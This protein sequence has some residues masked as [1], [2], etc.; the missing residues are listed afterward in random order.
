[1]KIQIYGELR[2]S[3]YLIT[4]SYYFDSDYQR[5]SCAWRRPQKI[6]LEPFC[7]S[8]VQTLRAQNFFFL[9]TFGSARSLTIILVG[10]GPGDPSSNLGRGCLHFT[11][12]L[13]AFR[14]AWIQQF[15]PQLLVNFLEWTGLF[16]LAMETGLWEGKLWIQTSCFPLKADIVSHPARGGGVG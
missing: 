6:S 7:I 1:M 11:I 2:W 10:K 4:I 13:I 16:C 3:R 9:S 12:A 5:C 8:Q 15:S 14:K